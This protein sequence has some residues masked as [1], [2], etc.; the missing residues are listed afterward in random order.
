M[1][2]MLQDFPAG[3]ATILILMNDASRYGGMD[4]FPLTAREGWRVCK[5]SVNGPTPSLSWRGSTPAVYLNEMQ[6]DAGSDK[7][8]SV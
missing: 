7:R 8:I 1:K 3:N 2:N 4:I 6:S 5:S